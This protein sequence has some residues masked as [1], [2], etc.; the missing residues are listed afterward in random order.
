MADAVKIG[1]EREVHIVLLSDILPSKALPSAIKESA[2]YK[3]IAQ[4]V[5]QLGL[6]EPLVVTRASKNGP[7]LLLDGHVRFSVLRDQSCNDARCI[8]AHD[9][10]AFTYN[11]R[12][13]RV[14]VIQEHRMIVRA[15]ENGVSEDRLASALS[16]D[17]KTIKARRNLLS[18]I[19]P[20]VAEILKDK[21]IGHHA[22]QFIRKMKPIR[23]LEVVELMVSANNFT[24]NYVKAL[25]A[26]T[27]AADLLKPDDPKKGVGLSPDQM[28]RLEREMS[29]VSADYKELEASYGDDMLLLV[30]A[31]GYLER[32]VSRP[33]IQRFMASQYP[34]FLEN[35]RTIV[36]ATSLDQT[37]M[38]A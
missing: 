10:E 24:N 7:Y 5:A 34:D 2:K 4:S 8:I 28:A 19:C 22:F 26:T 3:R 31:S 29:S 17:I 11:K 37:G 30:I 23:Q 35:F 6:V 36:A 16:M 38:A 15:I 32:L 14:A 18:G 1:F 20:E 12:I 9:D 27:K 33:E 13:S 21:P 25:L